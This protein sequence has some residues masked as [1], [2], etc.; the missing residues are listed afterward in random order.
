MVVK[1]PWFHG[2]C[3]L[4]G[5]M[6]VVLGLVA[7]LVNFIV[8]VAQSTQRYRLLLNLKQ[9][10]RRSLMLRTEICH[11]LVHACMYVHVQSC[12]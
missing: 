9:K 10:I 2:Q 3:E 5:A 8:D 7:N 1:V 12:T 6:V 4:H 11:K